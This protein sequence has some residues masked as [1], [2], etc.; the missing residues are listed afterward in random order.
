MDGISCLKHIHCHFWTLR[1]QGIGSILFGLC[2][3]FVLKPCLSV[4]VYAV[5]RIESVFRSIGSACVDVQL[6]GEGH[7]QLAAG[8]LI[9]LQSHSM[10]NV[11]K[12]GNFN[13]IS[14]CCDVN[15]HVL[16]L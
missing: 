16:R 12:A 8:V 6:N 14:I 10:V 3:F 9:V 1:Q 7:H 15:P 13:G 11:I 4:S 2:V 5:C